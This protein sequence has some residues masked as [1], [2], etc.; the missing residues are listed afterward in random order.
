MRCMRIRHINTFNREMVQTESKSPYCSR[1]Y[2]TNPIPGYTEIGVVHW[3]VLDLDGSIKGK[4]V[5]INGHVWDV[6][7]GISEVSFPYEPENHGDLACFECVMKE[8]NE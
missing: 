7:Q 1:C 5:D 8:L 3:V 4:A 2:T 6:Y